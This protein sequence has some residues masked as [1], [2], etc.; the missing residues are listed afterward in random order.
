[1][2]K[3]KKIIILLLTFNA[4]IAFSQNQNSITTTI[5]SLTI[6]NQGTLYNCSNI[7]IGQNTSVELA[8][9]A[10]IKREQSRAVGIGII[11]M[12]VKYNSTSAPVEI[13]TNT[14]PASSWDNGV[15]SVNV[16]GYYINLGENI[17][18]F[19]GSTLYIVYEDQNGNKYPSCNFTITKTKIPTFILTPATVSVPCGYP[20][21]PVIFTVNNVYNSPGTLLYEWNTGRDTWSQNGN[22]VN[23][24]FITTTNSITLTRLGNS[25]SNVTVSTYLNGVFQSKS[26]CITTLSSPSANSVIKGS[27]SICNLSTPEVY[28]ISNLSV[29][30]GVS[31]WTS[32]N[33]A[34]ATVSTAQSPFNSVAVTPVSKGSFNLTAKVTNSCGQYVDI[35]KT[36][37]VGSLVTVATQITGGSANVSVNSSESYATSSVQGATGYNWSISLSPACGCTTNSDGLTICPSGVVLPKFIDSGS[38]VFFSSTPNANVNWGNCNGTYLVSCSASNG[39]TP[40]LI[41]SR[42]INVYNPNGGGGGTNPNCLQKFSVSPNPSIDGNVTLRIP[43]NPCLILAKNSFKNSNRVEADQALNKVKIY[44]FLGSIKYETE[45]KDLNISLSNLNLKKGK[46]IVTILS[47]NANLSREILIVE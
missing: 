7:D 40:S 41:G 19:T 46:Y 3:M 38:P 37:T 4:L 23:G 24:T 1:M 13:F 36:I 29:G 17:V 16:A 43:P 15:L 28:S 35:T 42:S 32:S 30:S 45:F 5:N 34:I 8:F 39:C 12:S 9:I 47:E 21:N 25:L 20:S 18:D 14:V 22:I 2:K 6:K 44:D 31:L 11:R 27:N 33:P 26:N 10:T